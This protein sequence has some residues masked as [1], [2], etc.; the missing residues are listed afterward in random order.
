MKRFISF[1]LFVVLL[2]HMLGHLLVLVSMQWQEQ[3]EL[4]ERVT[5]FSSVDHIVEFQIPLQKHPNE[6]ILTQSKPEGFKYRGSFYEIVNLDV[7]GD[8]LHISGYV[9]KTKS[10]FQRDLLSFVKEQFATG[11]SES[12]KKAN[13]LLKLFLKEYSPINR[14]RTWFFLYEWNEKLVRI[15]SFASHLSTRSLPVYSPPPELLS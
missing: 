11:T 8:T 6:A 9:N 14:A 15:P 7:S 12:A 2:Y 4:S 10:F 5:V 3:H 1:G 13:T